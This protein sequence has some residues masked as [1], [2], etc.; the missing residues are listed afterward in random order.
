MLE[1]TPAT[2][3]NALLIAREIFTIRFKVQKDALLFVY[4]STNSVFSLD[5]HICAIHKE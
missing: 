4:Y 5:L 1:Q 3:E 2:I